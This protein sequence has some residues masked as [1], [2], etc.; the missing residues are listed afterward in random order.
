MF[1]SQS[2]FFCNSCVHTLNQTGYS[3][4][5]RALLGEEDFKRSLTSCVGANKCNALHLA[6]W[7]GHIECVKVLCQVCPGLA[8]QANTWHEFPELAA[9]N[10]SCE[11][12][13]SGTVDPHP[14]LSSALHCLRVREG[15]SGLGRE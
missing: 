5:L 12:A 4:C 14:F 7:D 13:M 10:K 15:N 2:L 8:S 9:F 6:A 11:H 1:D 3:E